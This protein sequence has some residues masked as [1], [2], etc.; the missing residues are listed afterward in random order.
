MKSKLYLISK[1]LYSSGINNTLL[2]ILN[3]E[4]NKAGKLGIALLEDG[5]TALTGKIAGE[6]NKLSGENVKFYA[7]K[8]D[9]D[10]RNLNET[11]Q[12]NSVIQVTYREL[13]NIIINDYE[14]VINYS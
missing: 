11:I 5:V 10:A 3:I 4:K 8:E 2:K 1:S 9:V 14:H 7:L 13:I 12:L 6:L